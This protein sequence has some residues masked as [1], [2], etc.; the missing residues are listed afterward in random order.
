[1]RGS[2]VEVA[3]AALDKG[4]GIPPVI[5][6][7]ERVERRQHTGIGHLKD[8]AREPRDAAVEIAIIAEGGEE[9]L[10]GEAGKV[11]NDAERNRRRDRRGRRDAKERAESCR[12]S[13][14]RR[15]IESSI[16]TFDDVGIRLIAVRAGHKR[17]EDR[18]RSRRG[19]LEDCTGAAAAR[20]GG[21][22]IEI[23]V[24]AQHQ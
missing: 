6:I 20:E 24:G 15:A 23:S 9:R 18:D 10:V 4:G 8:T 17:M 21:S 12:A 19:D 7:R 1:M 11:A 16:G 14:L 5:Q 22:S 3:I 2:A 13:A